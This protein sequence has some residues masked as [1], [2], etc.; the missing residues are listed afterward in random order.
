MKEV[1]DEYGDLILDAVALGGIIGILTACFFVDQGVIPTVFL[2][3]FQ[4]VL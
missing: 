4:S 2:T 3:A 1:M